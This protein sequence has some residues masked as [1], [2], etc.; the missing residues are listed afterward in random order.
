MRAKTTTFAVCILKNKTIGLCFC[1][2][3]TGELYATEIRGHDS[4]NV[5]TNQLTSYNPREILIGGDIVKLKELPKFIKS[6]T[7]GGS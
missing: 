1:D 3:S 6:E 2:I 7:F 4:Y 5:L